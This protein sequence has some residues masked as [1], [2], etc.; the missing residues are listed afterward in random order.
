M[1]A[2]LTGCV[3]CVNVESWAAELEWTAPTGCSQHA[4]VQQLEDT[5]ERGLTEIHLDALLV[6]VKV[7][8]D[9][10][11]LAEFSLTGADRHASPSRKITGTSCEDVSRAAAV[12]AAMAIHSL[13]ATERDDTEAVSPETDD[14]SATASTGASF[15]AEPLAR[16][17]TSPNA[18]LRFPLQLILLGDV[19][20][21]GTAT[22]AL[23]V[24]AGMG[25]ERWEVDLSAVL[26]AG[27]QGDVSDAIAVEL[28]AY[29]AM[30]SGCWI[31]VAESLVQ[32]RAC[33]GYEFGVVSGKGTG[34]GLAVERRQNA[35]WYAVRPELR[36]GVPLSS[37]VELRMG[38]GLAI[39]L[40]QAAFVIDAGRVGHE[41]PSSS[42]RG[43]LALTW[44][45]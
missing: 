12:A 18:P 11:W 29:V 25:R 43:A 30:A 5:V 45:P 36:I 10:S 20:L 42:L 7:S 34:A 6:K 2:A 24:G 16:F 21:L 26:F 14:A 40:S 19:A 41:L 37:S 9:G 35:L 3:F 27:V 13:R 22:Y 33:L 4:F 28:N 15:D 8:A 17:E 31:L 39:A 44:I 1:A 32:P 38:A 23:G